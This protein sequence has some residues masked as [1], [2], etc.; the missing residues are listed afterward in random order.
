[1]YWRQ[2]RNR[3]KINNQLSSAAISIIVIENNEWRN[4]WRQYQWRISSM[5][6]R[7]NNQWQ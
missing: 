4:E 1:M 6:Y 7:R 2:R 5:K 3:K